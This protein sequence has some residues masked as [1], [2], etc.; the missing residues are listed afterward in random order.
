MTKRRTYYK[1]TRA[2]GSSFWD[3]S[4]KYA[5]GT[6]TKVPRKGDSPA[7]CT[8]T[9]LHASST[10]QQAISWGLRNTSATDLRLFA[11]VGTPV[12]AERDDKVGF[13][14]IR[15]LRELNLRDYL[16]FDIQAIENLDDDELERFLALA[17]AA[18]C[19]PGWKDGFHALRDQLD[20][21]LTSSER[22]ISSALMNQVRPRMFGNGRWR[23]TEAAGFFAVV[24]TGLARA[25]DRPGFVEFFD[26]YR[27]LAYGLD[28]QIVVQ[29]PHAGPRGLPY[30]R[31]T[32]LRR[33]I[34]NLIEAEY[35]DLDA[36]I[37]SQ[38]LRAT[39]A[40]L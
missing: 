14:S 26:T 33:K 6:T 31:A 35:A 20:T 37:V 19:V 9:V 34:A 11:F 1:T 39:D 5:V 7:L 13:R 30:N 29:I 4:V 40:R 38:R 10:P 17:R 28:R 27:R 23:E 16:L 24:E 8:N 15:P 12:T 32:S 21:L 2:D 36:E 25:A 3:H 18:L 22:H